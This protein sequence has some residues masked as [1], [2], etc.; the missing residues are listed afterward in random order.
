M[1][2]TDCFIY[3]HLGLGDHIVCNG[4]VRYVIDNRQLKNVSLVVKSCNLNNV[5]RMFSDRDEVDFFVV[6]KDQDFLD[7]HQNNGDIPLLKV[8][9]EKCRNE[10]FD[11]SFYDSVGVSFNE[12]W[13]SWDLYRDKVQEQKLFDDLKIEDDYIFVHDLSSVGKYDLN[14]QSDL[15]KIRPEKLP[16]EETIFDWVGVIEEAEEV[17]AISS[18]FVH[19][20]DSFNLNNKLYF[21]NIKSGDGMGFSLKNDWTFINYG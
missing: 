18:S 11:R 8:G 21:H 9:F 1:E 13:D 3:H 12:R 20:I 19:L 4:L 14:I 6:E 7:Y 16:S 15:R 2:H 17:H 10:D 5:R